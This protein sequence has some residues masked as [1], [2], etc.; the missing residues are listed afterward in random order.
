MSILPKWK[1][2]YFSK[3]GVL[4]K[5][6]PE[7]IICAEICAELRQL[8]LH[9]KF[10]GQFFHVENETGGKQSAAYA[11]IKKVTGKMPGAP[12]YIF[13]MNNLCIFIEIKT[14][15]SKQ[16][17]AQKHFQSWAEYANNSYFICRS[18]EDV[19]KILVVHNF[20]KTE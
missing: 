18:W 2:F 1:S 4:S 13:A 12:D 20:I 19:K 7:D 3:W 5:G 10:K 17:T 16:N 9:D 11:M 15:D 8:I 6:N 14:K